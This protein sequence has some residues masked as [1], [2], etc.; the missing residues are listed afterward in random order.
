VIPYG[1]GLGALLGALS[2]V[3]PFA[4]LGLLA[5]LW[6]NLPG[7]I[8]AIG[9]YVALLLLAHPQT[10]PWVYGEWVKLEGSLNNGFLKTPRGLVY[11]KHFPPLQ[12]GS[13]ILEGRIQQPEKARNPGGFDQQ[14]WL[15]AQGIKAVLEV[16]ASQL[17]KRSSGTR[18]S[19]KQNLEKG[20]SPE[21]AALIVALTL[22]DKGDLSSTYATFQRAGLAHALA[23]SGLNVAILVG[24]FL[25]VFYKLSHWRYLLCILL[26]VAYLLLVGIQPSLLRAVIMACIVLLGL[27]LGKGRVQVFPAL[28][29]A[30]C[31]HL[32]LD[33]RTLFSLS[34]QLSYSAVLGMALVLPQ[35]PRLKGWAQWVWSSL[36]TTFAAQLLVL[37]L[38][39]HNFHALALWSPLANLLVLPLLN[40]LVPL[41]FL[42]LFLGGF[43]AWPVDWVSK[44]SLWLI[45]GLSHSPQLYW[46]SI[47]PVGFVLYFWALIPLFLALYKKIS[48]RHSLVLLSTA[49]LIAI[50]CKPSPKATLW[51]L[52]V[53]QGDAT[54]ICL[55]GDVN[56]LIDGGHQWAYNR[57][58]SSLRALGVNNLD[59]I[60]AT[61]PDADHIEALPSVMKHFPTKTLI[62][63]P[64]VEGDPLDDALYRNKGTQIL[65]ARQGSE[66]LVGE[67]RLR[68]LGPGGFESQDNDRSLIF[69]FQ[70][71]KRK[72]LFTG[73]APSTQE[74]LWPAEKVDILKVGHHGSRH[75]TSSALLTAFQPHTALVSVGKNTYGHPHQ[76]VLQR[77]DAQGVRIHRTD[78]EGAIR[79]SLD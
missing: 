4:F 59:L 52:D 39:L 44:A 49:L 6:L 16:H 69:V 14:S 1:L 77:L 58:E 10:N 48:W 40:L 26:L 29:L 3:T 36:A 65:Q 19:A 50:L 72:V 57:L 63:G 46:G 43:L 70:Y 12:D 18:E 34:A 41:G 27:F 42:K 75:S 47:S 8:G 17:I 23:L 28:S 79:V 5:G 66:F 20:L 60:I 2:Q 67:A 37:P 45:E 51:Q 21:S 11:V 15:A 68:F 73:D 74:S 62:T 31:L 55:P 76:E 32:L 71:K 78:L 9:A 25:L 54:L 24:F 64:R 7:R 35:L 30:V 22:G 56:I 38:L 33:P 53:G 61:H 13:Y